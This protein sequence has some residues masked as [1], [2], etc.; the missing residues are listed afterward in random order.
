MK[1][2]YAIL[3]VARGASEADIK[4]AYRKLAKQYHPDKNKDNP[5]AAEKFK[6][7]NEAYEV[8]TDAE[9]KQVYDQYGTTNPGFGGS[10]GMG[11]AGPTDFNDLFSQAMGNRGGRGGGINIEDL[12][13]GMGGAGFGQQSRRPRNVEGTLS[14]SVQEAF[15]GS[16]TTVTVQGKRLDVGIPAGIRAGKQL[17]LTGQAPSGG[18]VLLT[19]QY[20]ADPVFTLEGDDV[21]VSVEVPVLTA[22]LGGSCKVPTLGGNV[23]LTIPAGSSSGKVLRLRGQ[24]WPKL[25]SGRGDQLV[26]L[27]IVVPSK[28]SDQE[29]ALY[30]QIAALKA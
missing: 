21:R 30:Q 16:R 11:G 24:G 19:I 6:D 20:K 2:Y 12:L 25:T 14:I 10:G 5:K 4:S 26:R 22:I 29:R 7:I 15:E 1:D 17:R 27:E 23:E 8:L 18:D 13:G 3:G 28:L 9:K